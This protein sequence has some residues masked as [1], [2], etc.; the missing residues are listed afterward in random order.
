[1]LDFLNAKIEWLE[2]LL[3][4]LARQRRAEPRSA[5]LEHRCT[6]LRRRLD[7]V[8]QETDHPVLRRVSTRYPLSA[9]EREC[10]WLT[11]AAHLDAHLLELIANVHDD[12]RGN[13]VSPWICL[14][15]FCA[16]RR[17]RLAARPALM[18]EGPLRRFGLLSVHPRDHEPNNELHFELR[19]SPFVLGGVLGNRGLGGPMD[20]IARLIEPSLTL[21]EVAMTPGLRANL[22]SAT[23]SIEQYAALQTPSCGPAVYDF[24]RGFLLLLTGTPGC[25]K[26]LAARAL[27]AEHGKRLIQVDAALLAT[28]PFERAAAVMRQL[29][30]VAVFGDMWL[31]FDDCDKLLKAG[32][33]ESPIPVSEQALHP[34]F[35]ARLNE[36][37][38][39]VIVTATE[40]SCLADPIR[41]RVLAHHELTPLSQ[42]AAQLAWQLNVPGTIELDADVDFRALTESFALTGRNIQNALSTVVREA[43]DRPVSQAQLVGGAERQQ[44]RGLGRVARRS[45]VKRARQDLILPEALARQVDEIIHTEQI[46]EAVLRE[47]GLGASIQTGLGITCL[48]NG[49]PGTGKTMAAEVIA[50]TLSLPLYVVNVSHV[51]SKWIGETEKNLQRIFDD[52]RRNRCVVLF[53]EADMLFAKRTAVRGSVDRYANMEVG[54]LLQLMEEYRGLVILTTNLKQSMDKAFERRIA[55]KLDFPLPETAGRRQIWQVLLP[56]PYLAD[57]VDLDGLAEEFEL[58]GGNIRTVVLQAAYRAARAGTLITD[59]VI[60]QAAT[61]ECKAL[62]QLVREEVKDVSSRR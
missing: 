39:V 38:A 57:D 50:S 21:D 12:A 13:Y 4:R 18:G 35:R 37:P 25:G 44:S 45:W 31:L 24:Q 49:P 32:P 20:L 6:T 27:A 51:V 15:L 22:R 30:E 60:R 9:F 43:P 3:L 42:Q 53:D 41:D 26:T 7:Q 56:H 5:E 19:P 28:W 61:N 16:S 29:F 58:G 1:M 55:F 62:G 17:E 48:F 46:R 52:A 33:D 54:L 34:L 2:L 23:T 8:E 11:V 10:L 59:E 36:R 14:R 47:W 40:P